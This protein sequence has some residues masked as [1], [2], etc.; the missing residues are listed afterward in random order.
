MHPGAG[1]PDATLVNGLLARFPEISSVGE[2]QRPGIVHR[3]DKGTSGLLVIARTPLAYD[4]LVG[5]LA[6]HEAHRGYRALAWGEF[7]TPNGVVDAPIGRSDR[8]PTKMA[9][10]QNGR[11]ARTRYRVDRT[12]T[13]PVVVS[14]LTCELETGRT[15][16]I[17]VHLAAIGHPIV[18]DNRYRGTRPGLH[19]DRP[20]LHAATLRFEH[21]ETGDEMSFELPLPADLVAVL[22]TLA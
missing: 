7:E 10:S 19:V 2:P 17:R 5:Q 9:V 6:A 20:W 4:D 3:L 16:Q 12:F 13:D 22:D 18:G 15:H 11:E 14:L 8:D 1:N 21:P